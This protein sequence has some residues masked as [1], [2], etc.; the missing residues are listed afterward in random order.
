MLIGKLQYSLVVIASIP[1]G[2][3]RR[4]G[5]G[6]APFDGKL[7]PPLSDELARCSGQSAIPAADALN[8]K[9]P[10]RLFVG[11]GDR[12]LHDRILTIDIGDVKG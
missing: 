6:L 8:L 12:L 7:H 4:G 10:D 1:S 2:R 9:M 11:D 5:L 3:G